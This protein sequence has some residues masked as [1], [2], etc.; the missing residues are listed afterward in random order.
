MPLRTFVAFVAEFPTDRGVDD[1]PAGRQLARFVS[2]QLK[3]A[4]I[5]VRE[6][7]EHAGWAWD[8]TA[9]VDGT[10]ID[11]IVGLVDDMDSIPP[12]QWL[13]TNDS[14][15]SLW[16]R[17]FASS[18]RRHQRELALR[19]Y[20]EALHAALTAD[21]RFSHLVWYNKETFDRP[22]DEPGSSP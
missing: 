15:L 3:N 22:L 14:E 6:P 10:S 18:G 9:N 13:I 7:E 17:M 1:S 20:C 11:T 5:D 21:P 2:A 8:I 16:S 4:G 12:R 19:R